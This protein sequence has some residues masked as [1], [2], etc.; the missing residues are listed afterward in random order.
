MRRDWLN[1]VLL[2]TATLAVFWRVS[3][4]EFVN[5][6]DY[7][8]VTLNPTVQ[9][10][11]TWAGIAW[12]FGQLHGEATYWHPVTWL[13]HMLDCQWFGLNPAGHH[14]G[15]LFFHTLN[16]LL[17]F[18]LLRRTTGQRGASAVVA[19]LFALHPLQVDSV[20][21]VAER[22]NVLST[23]FGLLA[24]LAYVRYA[25]RPHWT[26]YMPV[27]VLLAL[28][29]MAKPMLVTLPCVML[30]LDYWPL[31]RLPANFFRRDEFRESP[32]Q[33][34]VGLIR[35]TRG[36]PPSEPGDSASETRNSKP[37][38]RNSLLRLLLEKLPLLA[39]SAA[40]SW[41]TIHGH[42]ALGALLP[43]EELPLWNRLANAAVSYAAYLRKVIW[44]TDLSVFYLHPGQWPAGIVIG[45]ALLLLVVSAVTLH[46]AHRRPYL[47]VGWLWFLGTLVPTIGL[48]QAHTQALA[49]RFA[50]L[51][52]IGLFVMVVW[53][54]ADLTARVRQPR[55]LQITLAS[56]ALTGCVVMTSLQLRHWQNSLTLLTRA[57]QMAGGDFT[58]R[59]MLGNAY[60]ERGQHEA[61]LAE[62]Q[63]AIR[64]RRDYAEAWQRAGVTLNVL[65]RPAEAVQH[66]QTAIQLSP[67]WPDPRRGLGQT[68][69]RLGR[70]QEARAAYAE[71]AALMPRT[72]KGHTQL[73]EMLV[74]GQQPAEAIHHYREALRLEPGYLPTMNNL[75]WL[76]ATCA[77]AE[78]RDG[79]EAVQLA[80]RACQLSRRRFPHFLGSLAAA[81]A[82]AGRFAEAVQ[83]IREA[84][85]L[86]QKSG[87]TNL[88]PVHAQM[89]AQFKAGQPVREGGP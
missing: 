73:A 7:A 21:W 88:L 71:L 15:N 20:A 53:A 31:R 28:G 16:T 27:F 3:R 44:P 64:L 65:G 42:K 74:E 48:V 24:L 46:Q 41:V 1:L 60:F 79:A 47:L 50:Y 77:Q 78:W 70:K 26:R 11:L 34:R 85:A 58:A 8:Y 18:V 84:Q 17:L 49:D 52:L 30:L 6:D 9:Q 81:Y 39:L 14:L 32:S 57:V 59:V 29:L 75:A 62:Y 67:R 36:A 51:P 69:V 55:L 61:A 76:R 4:H 19:A 54:A 63:E 43:I 83:A 23:L 37:G 89:E 13:S 5:Y 68:L 22:K 10:G 56:V 82:E 38:T 12:A 66:F 35:G 40:S 72:A 45:S 25:A 86:A 2:A 87:A 33:K 80:E